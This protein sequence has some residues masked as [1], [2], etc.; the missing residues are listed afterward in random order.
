MSK[1]IKFLLFLFVVFISIPFN[2]KAEEKY[3][4][5][6]LK[7]TLKE[8]GIEESFSKY[9]ETDDQITIYLFRGK[10]CGY[11]RKFLTFLNSITDEYGKYFKLQSY[12]VWNDKANSD[13]M[14][15]VAD[16]LGEEANGVPFIIIG[17]KTFP[18]F[19]EQYEEGIKEAITDLY[20]TKKKKR[21]D[22]FTEMKKHPK[23]DSNATSSISSN[24]FWGMIILNL[25]F[26]I[27]TITV[28]N[29]HMNEKY[30]SLMNEFNKLNENINKKETKKVTK[31]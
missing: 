5:L 31:K 24:A 20:N 22:V 21:Y 3:N 17:D 29:N 6:N 23:K 26:T 18:G 8:E 14:K 9:K 19:A 15:E 7:E 13:L 25:L 2:V 30:N 4:T 11:C 28:I 1:K 27:I 16:Y 10:G 12:E